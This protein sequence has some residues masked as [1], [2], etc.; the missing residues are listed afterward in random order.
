MLTH[1]GAHTHTPTHTYIDTYA[2]IYTK[3]SLLS[4]NIH[5]VLISQFIFKFGWVFGFYGISTTVGYLTPDPVYKYKSNIY[6]L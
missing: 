6:D 3:I 2:Y 4:L 5:H 1:V